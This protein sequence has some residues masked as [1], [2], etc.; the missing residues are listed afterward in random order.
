MLHFL[1]NFLNVRSIRVANGP[2]LSDGRNQ[3]NGLPTGSVLSVMLF[4]SKINGISEIIAR[5]NPMKFLMDA[6][7]LVIYASGPSIPKLTQLLH[8]KKNVKWALQ[9]GFEFS[10]WGSTQFEAVENF[11]FLDM[12]LDIRL[13]WDSHLNQLKSL[14]MKNSNVIR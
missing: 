6:D 8:K 11:K 5:F 9:I 10:E 1:N 2:T 14:L 4:L 13:N 7:D 3:K 12:V